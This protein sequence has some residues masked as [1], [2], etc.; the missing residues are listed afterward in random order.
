MPNNSIWSPGQHL[1]RS[2]DGGS[3]RTDLAQQQVQLNREVE[4]AAPRV[5]KASTA[6][7]PHP[8]TILI[9]SCQNPLSPNL[10]LI[11]CLLHFSYSSHKSWRFPW[12]VPLSLC[13]P[14]S[15]FPHLLQI[16]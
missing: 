12:R 9:S 4:K 2:P 14:K 8:T 11:S 7:H 13:S 10:P 6:P 15:N 16:S 5:P 3:H 1:R